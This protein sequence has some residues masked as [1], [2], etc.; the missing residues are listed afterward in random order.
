MKGCHRC[1]SPSRRR[2]RDWT[3]TLHWQET[4]RTLLC[5]CSRSC[6]CPRKVALLCFGSSSKFWRSRPSHPRED[7][8]HETQAQGRPG[9]CNCWSF[10][11][12]LNFIRGKCQMS[13]QSSRCRRMLRRCVGLHQ[14]GLCLARAD[15]CME[16]LGPR[17][18]GHDALHVAVTSSSAACAGR[19]VR[20]DLG[21][22]RHFAFRGIYPKSASDCSHARG[23][24]T[25]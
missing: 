18:G 3:R 14:H 15:A 10:V 13:C 2:Q 5:N 6:R 24:T 9:V 7:H 21:A 11:K 17:R 19:R 20:A 16:C 23:G 25:R 1:R 12:G 22:A 8:R 4:T